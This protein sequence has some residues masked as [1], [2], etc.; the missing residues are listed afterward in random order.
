MLRNALI[1]IAAGSAIAAAVPLA[2][3]S[4]GQPA[5]GAGAA[6]P[7]NTQTQATTQMQ[8]VTPPADMAT[9]SDTNARPADPKEKAKANTAAT[10]Q[11]VV[12]AG[13]NR[14]QVIGKCKS[15]PKTDATADDKA[16]PK[17]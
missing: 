10:C 16:D 2:A 7:T 3:Q 13:P 14:G 9:T 8:A 6:A 17:N 4:T 11:N 15:K 1:A 12:A 5:A